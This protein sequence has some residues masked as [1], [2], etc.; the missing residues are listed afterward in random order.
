MGIKSEFLASYY[1]IN[2]RI[3]RIM[4]EKKL[5]HK[6]V[7][8]WLFVFSLSIG[9]LVYKSSDFRYGL[10]LNGGTSLTYVADL[11]KIEKANTDAALATS[12]V[13][14]STGQKLATVEN[15]K[16]NIEDSM[17]GLQSVIEKRINVFGVSEPIVRTEYSK[18]TGEHRLVVELPGVTDINKAIATIG[19]TPT[20]EFK[21]V[22]IATDQNGA[23]STQLIDTGLNGNYLKKSVLNFDSY[24]NRPVVVVSFNE[25]GKKLFAELT[26]NNTGKEMSIFLDG[27]IV[28]SP[29]IQEEI[30][31]GEATISGSF[32][33][34]EAKTLVT[35]L[36]S[37]ALPVPIKL[38]SSQ[39]IEATLGG[40]AKSQGLL[41]GQIGFLII[42]ILMILWYRLPGILS[43]ISLSA[44][45]AIVLFLFKEIPVVL[46][47]AGIAGFIISMGVAIDANILIFE[48]L[49]EEIKRGRDL[50]TAVDEAFKRAWTSI[51]DSNIASIL[52]ALTLF[53]F[54]SSLLAG[55]GLVFG[56]GV[57]VSMF[58][59]MVIS[60]YFLLAFVPENTNS[61]YYKIIKALFG[62]GF[63]K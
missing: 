60:K 13:S 38:A 9:F 4:K 40:Q 6:V 56:I 8:F 51:R 50:Q 10:D 58:S 5:V 53:Y 35:R 61:K 36:N 12:T 47:S 15:T 54:G 42:A 59:S 1:L 34:Q 31:G 11:A 57:L 17:S 21:L 30:S 48:R 28:S 29:V 52:V 41:A 3:K 22:N 63:S 19:D 45:T 32:T 44:Y 26:K 46:T 24:T 27:N 55:F 49:K 37:G 7:A 20:L 39:V 16:L 2:I 18:Y 23:T 62:S 14:T 43:V 33:V 25:E